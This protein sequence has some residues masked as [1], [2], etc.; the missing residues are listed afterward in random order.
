MKFV[1]SLLNVARHGQVHCT[2]AVVPGK[3]DATKERTFPVFRV[4]FV[5]VVKCIEE[6]LCMFLVLIL[7]TKIVNN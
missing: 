6:V 3:G 1:E 4:G 5:V 2:L 7:D